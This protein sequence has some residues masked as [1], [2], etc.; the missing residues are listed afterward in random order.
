MHRTVVMIR[1]TMVGIFGLGIKFI[2]SLLV[3]RNATGDFSSSC[4][5]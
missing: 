5:F 1:T 4:F 3:N 2:T